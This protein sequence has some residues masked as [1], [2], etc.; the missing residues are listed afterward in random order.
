MEEQREIST[1]EALQSQSSA[2]AASPLPSC[3][4]PAGMQSREACTSVGG[5]ISHA[6]DAE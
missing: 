2:F 5:I 6:G 1:H 3:V 4:D